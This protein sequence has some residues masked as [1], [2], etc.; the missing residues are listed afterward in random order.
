MG[1]RIGVESQIGCGSTFRF[2]VNVGVC[3]PELDDGRPVETSPPPAAPLPPLRILLAEDNLVNQKVA[4]RLLENAGCE[5][6]AVGDGHAALERWAAGQFDVIFMDVQMPGMDG[7]A[8]T[9]AIRARERGTGI[10][11][12]IVAMTALAMTGDRER[13]LSAGMDGYISKPVDRGELTEVLHRMVGH[14][15]PAR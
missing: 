9:E 10:H 6:T 8:A 11:I 2:T 14:G 12:P 15:Q 5:V 13:C 1:G 4:R 7:F 3:A